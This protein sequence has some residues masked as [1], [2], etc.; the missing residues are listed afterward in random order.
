MRWWVAVPISSRTS[1]DIHVRASITFNKQC[2]FFEL[3]RQTEHSVSQWSHS[4]CIPC[5]FVMITKTNRSVSDALPRKCVLAIYG[6]ELGA[7]C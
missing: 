7:A 2:L 4:L 3:K 5:E 6:V 1:V